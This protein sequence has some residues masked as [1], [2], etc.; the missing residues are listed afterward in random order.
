M[1]V[2]PVT[3]RPLREAFRSIPSIRRESPP[4]TLKTFFVA[5]LSR[6]VGFRSLI[7]F[8]EPPMKLPYFRSR[9]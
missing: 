8:T 7:S 5:F 2:A 9:S 4:T 6:S 1:S 3:K